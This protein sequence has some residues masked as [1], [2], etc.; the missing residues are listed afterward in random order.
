MVGEEGDDGGL[1]GPVE[2]GAGEVGAEGDDLREEGVGPVGDAQEED[3][4]VE[5]VEVAGDQEVAGCE[6]VGGGGRGQED[7]ERE[8]RV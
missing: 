2:V 5:G 6:V 8:E 7:G 4:G 3:A 1:L